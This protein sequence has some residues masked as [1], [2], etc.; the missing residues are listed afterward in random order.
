MKRFC[1]FLIITLFPYISFGQI[2]QRDVDVIKNDTTMF[3]GLSNIC[4]SS[5]EA[6]E[7]ARAALLDNIVI[8]YNKNA[9]LIQENDSD[10]LKN[11]VKTFNEW[12]YE[13]SKE[14]PLVD[15]NEDEHYQ[16]F[17]YIKR[18]DF[19][20]IC[21]TRVNYI[22]YY[23]SKGLK[24]EDQARYEDALK[25]YYWALV[26]TYAHP[27]GKKLRFDFGGEMANYERIIEHIG[28]D[29]GILESLVFIIPK[30]NGIEETPN[31]MIV[32]LKVINTYGN[33]V[34][35]LRCECHDGHKFMPNTVRDGKLIVQIQDTNVKNLKIKINYDFKKDA[36]MINPDVYYAMTL[37]KTPRFS[38][39]I[40]TV[41][42]EETKNIKQDKEIKEW[43]KIEHNN[44]VSEDVYQS[45][46]TVI[47][48]A[49]RSGDISLAR[50]C[51]S[52][53]G[54]NMF[55]TLFHYGK[56]TVVGK[57]EYKFLSY[58]NEVLCRSLTVQFEFNKLPAISQDVVFRFDTINKVVTSLAFR[59]SYQVETDIIN[60][61]KWPEKS[62]LDLVNI[63]EDYQTAYALKRYRYI[64]NLYSDDN[65]IIVN[66]DLKKI[67]ALD[68]STLVLKAEKDMLRYEKE[69]YIILLSRCF[70]SDESILF[71]IIETNIERGDNFGEVYGVVISQE[72]FT[73]SY[74]DNGCLYLLIDLIGD[75]P[76]ILFSTWKSGAFD[77]DNFIRFSDIRFN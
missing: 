56:L 53:D 1:F 13:R 28:G 32:N 71:R 22:Q 65:F 44:A 20:R 31:G 63:L 15:D 24:M 34:E 8:N 11:I 35:N 50:K 54:Y 6:I 12:I 37:I 23:I 49:L 61:I 41:N 51:F 46:M 19:R 3:Y 17:V 18:D 39:N 74:S 72:F 42:L 45:K 76:I 58:N 43:T 77:I 30:E 16:Y 59:L 27:Q 75:N 38:N 67:N 62:R 7:N 73:S 21:N 33:N 57:P 47:E 10:Q 52:E 4:S 25:S 5:D 60:K 40:Y 70:K 55:E 9:V 68:R 66:H 14:I 29:D 48:N 69:Q 26:L 64:E 2:W 36:Q